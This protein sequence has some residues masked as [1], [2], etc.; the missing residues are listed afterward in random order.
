MQKY[1]AISFSMLVT[2]AVE[3]SVFDIMGVK[4]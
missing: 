4:D 1:G 2:D 3:K